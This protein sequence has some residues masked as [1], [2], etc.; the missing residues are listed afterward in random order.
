MSRKPLLAPRDVAGS[1]TDTPRRFGN[2]SDAAAR[3]SLVGA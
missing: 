2:G 1:A 3:E